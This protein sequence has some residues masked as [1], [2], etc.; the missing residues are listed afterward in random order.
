MKLLIVGYYGKN[1]GDLLMLQGLM[2]QLKSHSISILTYGDQSALQCQSFVAENSVEVIQVANTPVLKI[3]Q[4]LKS[5]DALIWGGGTCFMDEGGTGGVKYA[6]LAYLLGTKVYY[7]GIGVDKH[8]RVKT[9]ACMLI[10][11]LISRK[12]YFR[13]QDSLESF[14]K[15]GLTCNR[16][17]SKTADL[18]YLPATRPKTSMTLKESY[19]A[20]CLRDLSAY[21]SIPADANEKLIVLTAKIASFLKITTVVLINA[22]QDVDSKVTTSAAKKLEERGYHTVEV[23]GSDLPSSISVIQHASFILTVRLHP[24]L[25]A[26]KAQVPFAVFN[27]S[28]K[29]RKMLVDSGSERHL[30]CSDDLASYEP[31]YTP[32]ASREQK[33]Q[34]DMV[35]DT[36]NALQEDLLLFS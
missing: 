3:L 24:A 18:A 20:L 36:L 16:K 25:V 9:K 12:I 27:Y 10:A 4:L 14:A 6:S 11:G 7:L 21:S 22:D 31:I 33:W 2:L 17:L 23:V 28:D 8:H 5:V 13:D 29:N 34:E 35:L 30:I 32:P 15:I 19:V 1:F 26:L